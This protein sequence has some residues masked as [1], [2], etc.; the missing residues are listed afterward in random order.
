VAKG[1]GDFFAAR[2]PAD[3]ADRQIEVGAL[4]TPRRSTLTDLPLDQVNPNPFQART[5]FTDLEELVAAIAAQG[6]ISR[7]RVRP[8]PQQAGRFELVYG[9]RR[10]R[11]AALLGLA[12]V[13]VEIAEHTDA[14]MIEIGLA[15]NIQRRDLLPLEEATAFRQLLA[16][17][18]YS[19]RSLAARIGKNPTYITDRT[20][21]LAAP[22]DVQEMV[23][24][25]PDSLRAAREISKV[26]DPAQ[27][28]PLI[29]G[30]VAGTLNTADVRT[31]VQADPVAPVPLHR[32]SGAAA[33]PAP[34]PPSADPAARPILIA[35]VFGELRLNY[36][37]E[38]LV[39]AAIAEFEHLF[40]D[41]VELRAVR[42]IGPKGGWSAFGTLRARQPD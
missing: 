12:T 14:E 2:P 13:P 6:F 32:P 30:V 25:R 18:R 17:G 31:L 28:A 15:E 5:D 34:A 39:R 21:A 7:L 23:A 1:K 10:L 40:G 42:Q 24:A 4:L 26:E 16:S 27:R 22:A 36:P 38:E 9:E 37:T 3:A 19:V 33:T 11:A 41:R 35:D 20:A 8:A 29:A